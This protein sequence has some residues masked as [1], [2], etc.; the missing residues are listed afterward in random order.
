MSRSYEPIPIPL[1]Q[2]IRELRVRVLP[3]L[4][5]IGVGVVVA[6]L[7]T[8]KVASPGMM[9]VV[10]ADSSSVSSPD[11]GILI[12]FHTE[13]FDVVQEGQLLGQIKRQDSLLLNAQL[14][15]I[16]SEIELIQQNREPVTGEQR[17]RMDLEDLKIEEINTRISLA[18]TE[19]EQRQAEADYHRIAELWGRD[20]VAEQEYETA[21]T[22]LDLLNVQVQEY[23]GLVEYLSERIVELEEFTG[24]HTRADRDPVLAAIKVQEQRMEMLLAES[25]PI[26]VYASMSG[27]ISFVSLKSGEYARAGDQILHI[28]SREPSYIVGYLRQP[29]SIEP[30]AGMAVQVRTRKPGRAFFDSRIE[31]LGGHVQ[32]MD[33]QLQRPGATFESGLPVKVPITDT[34]DIQLNPGE[35]VDIVLRPE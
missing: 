18:R 27:V 13:P 35:I 22:T 14:N 31:Q 25:A 3:F 16:R 28:E 10:V 30:E 19:L 15:L 8:D 23:R 11:H 4:V 17:A 34:G 2:W 12:N 5:F 26:P 1:K 9:G 29:F 32:V 20:L 6:F 24:Y 21:R 33:G 7:W